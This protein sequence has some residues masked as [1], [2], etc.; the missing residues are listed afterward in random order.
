MTIKVLKE[1]LCL[2]IKKMLK[3]RYVDFNMLIVRAKT[4]KIKK[5][6]YVYY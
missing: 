5:Q 2:Q 3:T 6:G 4:I 1:Y